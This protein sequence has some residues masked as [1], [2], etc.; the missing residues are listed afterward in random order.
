[1]ENSSNIPYV[2]IHEPLKSLPEGAP[3]EA[4]EAQIMEAFAASRALMD[5]TSPA[6]V[7]GYIIAMQKDDGD[8]VLGIVGDVFSLIKSVN[9][10][11][12][13]QLLNTASQYSDDEKLKQIVSQMRDEYEK[14]KP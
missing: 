6:H 9:A 5:E 2:K 12:T 1:M 10:A 14:D 8:V 3:A 7:E 11:I 4:A 13:Y